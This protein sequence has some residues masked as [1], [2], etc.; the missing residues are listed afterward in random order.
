MYIYIHIYIYIYTYIYI[1][2]NSYKTRN[3]T[4]RKARHKTEVHYRGCALC[5]ATLKKQIHGIRGIIAHLGIA[6]PANNIRR[7]VDQ[8]MH[9]RIQSLTQYMIPSLIQE[10]IQISGSGW[11]LPYFNGAKYFM[12]GLLELNRVIT[13]MRS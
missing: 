5:A 7:L 8:S 4:R 11:M 1:T 6:P 3:S 12:V 2:T 10:Q 9:G 13:R